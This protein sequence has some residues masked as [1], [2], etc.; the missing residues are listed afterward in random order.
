MRS[1]LVGVVVAAVAVGGPAYGGDVVDDMERRPEA[2]VEVIEPA[3]V[4][5]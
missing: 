2:A 4:R 1:I 3:P 5:H